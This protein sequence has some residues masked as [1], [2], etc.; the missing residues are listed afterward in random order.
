MKLFFD[1]FMCR[2]RHC[3]T[4]QTASLPS[5]TLCHL[6][7]SLCPVRHCLTRHTASLSGQTH[8]AVRPSVRPSVRP[9]GRP[10]YYY[11]YTLSDPAHNLSDPANTRQIVRC[12]RML[13]H[14]RSY[15]NP[16][17]AGGG[18]GGRRRWDP[19]GLDRS[20]DSIESRSGIP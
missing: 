20:I 2:E 10:A 11:Y 1:H 4:R 9:A 3:L 12:L 14:A 7:Q 5:Q 17:Q 18:G 8:P 15:L 16:L 13:T 6:A 19:L